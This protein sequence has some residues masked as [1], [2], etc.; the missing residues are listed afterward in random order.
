MIKEDRELLEIKVDI[1]N[2]GYKIDDNNLVRAL[3]PICRE[4]A[5][6]KRLFILIK[7]AQIGSM[8]FI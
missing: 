3:E 1:A 5:M 2:T 7:K 8:C 6:E 4:I